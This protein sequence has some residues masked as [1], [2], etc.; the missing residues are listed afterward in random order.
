MHCLFDI[1]RGCVGVKAR[2][3]QL[4]CESEK[5]DNGRTSW[6]EA[7]CSLS[8]MLQ[9]YTEALRMVPDQIEP[10]AVK[11]TLV[12]VEN[13][14]DDFDNDDSDDEDNEAASD[15]S[16]ATALSGAQAASEQLVADFLRLH[17]TPDGRLRNAFARLYCVRVPYLSKKQLNAN[18]GSHKV[19]DDL[20]QLIAREAAAQAE[21]RNAAGVAISV[22]DWHNAVRSLCV[23]SNHGDAKP[24]WTYVPPKPAAS[25]KRG[26]VGPHPPIVKAKPSIRQRARTSPDLL[27]SASSSPQP[28]QRSPRCPP[29]IKP[30]PR[31]KARGSSCVELSSSTCSSQPQR[32]QPASTALN[33]RELQAHMKRMAHVRAAASECDDNKNRAS[34]SSSLSAAASSSSQSLSSSPS[35]LA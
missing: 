5:M 11:P 9:R 14:V 2:L 28:L 16:Q 18:S 7:T 6:R 21:D 35:P 12:L 20:R 10:L 19:L 13:M 24:L 31:P 4:R 3:Q 1:G 29:A 17:D 8:V 23:D 25:T 27:G 33:V 26:G 22:H 32:A 34:S 30:K 15:S